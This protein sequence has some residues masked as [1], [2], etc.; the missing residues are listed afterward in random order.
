MTL[1]TQAG[2]EF[3]ETSHRY[4]QE[5]TKLSK[6]SVT[7]I[8][9]MADSSDGLTRWKCRLAAQT[10]L[11]H[12]GHVSEGTDDF[13]ELVEH[14][15]NEGDR[16]GREASDL[17]T[18][19]HKLIELHINNKLNPEGAFGFWAEPEPD[20]ALAVKA[21]IKYVDEMFI[22]IATEVRVVHPLG[23]SGSADFIGK[24]KSNPTGNYVLVDFKSKSPT[25]FGR[26]YNK[27]LVQIS[28][29]RFAL[30]SISPTNKFDGC[31][32]VHIHRETGKIKDFFLRDT[33]AEHNLFLN[34]VE[35]AQYKKPKMESLAELHRTQPQ[36]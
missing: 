18:R 21:G 20:I 35:V 24:L 22:P 7:K 1:V 8:A 29:Y 26:L 5:D 4:T 9:G 28:A 31:V 12:E 6:K 27:D 23:V 15:S 14:Y 16:Q 30:E 2:I 10:A 17:G 34:L 19:I 25:S 11:L 13:S 36:N 32:I 33:Q 3:D